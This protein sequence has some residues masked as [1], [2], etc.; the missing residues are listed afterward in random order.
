MNAISIDT[1]DY[2]GLDADFFDQFARHPARGRDEPDTHRDR[3]EDVEVLEPDTFAMRLNLAFGNVLLLFTV[4][5]VAILLAL[6]VA[7]IITFNQGS[8]LSG[9][10]GSVF[11][12]FTNLFR[13]G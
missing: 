12:L 6:A 11:D 10:H 5:V 9:G 4:F 1:T 3:D 13:R 7:A 2:F 8:I